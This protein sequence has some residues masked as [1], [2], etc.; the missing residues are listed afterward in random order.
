MLYIIV[1]LSNQEGKQ[2]VTIC[3]T[4][5]LKAYVKNYDSIVIYNKH[6]DLHKIML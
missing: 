5:K 3:D 2:T 4:L 6:C 1:E